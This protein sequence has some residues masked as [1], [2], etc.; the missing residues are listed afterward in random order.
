VRALS[1]LWFVVTK[2]IKEEYMFI[3]LKKIR[4]RTFHSHNKGRLAR[5]SGKNRERK[6][7]GRTWIRGKLDIG[8]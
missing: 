8:S 7:K 4:V 1:P 6:R 2:P 5:E 3:T